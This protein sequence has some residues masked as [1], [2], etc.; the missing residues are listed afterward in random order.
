MTIDLAHL[1][2]LLEKAKFGFY[3]NVGVWAMLE[4]LNA[5]PELLAM[6][7][8]ASTPKATN[9]AS[10]RGEV[11]QGQCHH[12]K[13]WPGVFEEMRA[14]RKVAE[15]RLNDRDYKAGDTLLI[16]EW[17]PDTKAYTHREISR[18]ITHVLSEG[19]G[20]PNGYAML[21]LSASP[22]SGEVERLRE[23]LKP[24]AEE[25]ASF[26]GTNYSD[27]E[28]AYADVSNITVGDLRAALNAISASTS[29]VAV[30]GSGVTRRLND[31]QWRALRVKI[32]REIRQEFSCTRALFERSD[33]LGDSIMHA[34]DAALSTTPTPEASM[35]EVDL[36]L[37]LRA[38]RE[39]VEAYDDPD[40]AAFVRL[41]AL[42]AA[43]SPKESDQ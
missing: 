27:H 37:V 34:V 22:A 39:F 9:P 43:L 35:G 40:G 29:P 32:V 5:L 25:A 1:R 7:E 11:A 3:D 8:D 12:I 19:F 30:D 41:N 17:C 13:C 15:Y 24:F 18:L 2:G 23:A 20:M 33:V 6:L 42:R 28:A 4:I 14:G 26:D 21:S 16:R 10:D 31:K 36:R 38:A